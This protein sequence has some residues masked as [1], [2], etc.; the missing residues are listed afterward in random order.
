MK[1]RYK[2]IL[3]KL[4][5]EAL[6]GKHDLYN[7][8]HIKNIADQIIALTKE[9]TEVAVVIG[10]GNIWRGSMAKGIGMDR[11]NGDYMGMLATVMNALALESVLKKQGHPKVVVCSALVINELSEPFYHKKVNHKLDHGYI[12]IL[13]AGLGHPYFTTDSAASLRAIQVNADVLMMAKNNVSGVYTAD[14]RTNKN[15][16][17]LQEISLQDLIKLKLNVMDQTASTLALDGKLDMIVFN[18][19][20]QNGLYKAAHHQGQFTF[21]RGK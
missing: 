14:P 3:I 19:N 20:D 1:P 12:V 15:A 8:D 18:I 4:S 17:H 7:S 9:G 11:V 5:G 6:K 10:G 16:E 2:R 21:I 13:P